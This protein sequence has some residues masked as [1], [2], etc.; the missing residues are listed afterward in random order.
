MIDNHALVL[1]FLACRTD[2]HMTKHSN[3]VALYEECCYHMMMW[4]IYHQSRHQLLQIERAIGADTRDSALFCLISV[5]YARCN[6]P[7]DQS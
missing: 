3:D 5:L 2:F 6:L 4:L 1:K 7:Q